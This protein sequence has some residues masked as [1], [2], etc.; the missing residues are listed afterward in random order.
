MKGLRRGKK[1]RPRQLQR[2]APHRLV[3]LRIPEFANAPFVA[4]GTR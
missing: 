1:E 2:A 3:E 4:K